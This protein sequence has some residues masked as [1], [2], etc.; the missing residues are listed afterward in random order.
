MQKKLAKNIKATVILCVLNKTETIERCVDS[1]LA[2]GGGFV[3]EILIVD[4]G[5]K[6]GSWEKLQKYKNNS[7]IRLLE[8][9]GG[10][11]KQLNYAIGLA[12]Y[13]YIALTDA[14]CVVDK[15][16]LKE[17]VKGFEESGVVATAGYCG[18]PIDVSKL[19][20]AIGVELESRFKVFPEYLQR[21]PT[22]SLC[23][24]SKIAKKLLFDETIKVG[25]ETDFGYRL[26][27]L[28]KIKYMPNS[29]VWHYHRA[30][31]KS[32]F[33]Q[34]WNTARGA[35]WVY[36]KHPDKVTGDHITTPQMM[37]EPL[38]MGLIIVTPILSF[39][40]LSARWLFWGALVSF[41]FLAYLRIDGIKEKQGVEKQ[42][43]GIILVRNLAFVIG[44]LESVYWLVTQ[45][46]KQQKF[47]L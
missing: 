33:K 39:L 12:K 40:S 34:Q 44:T 22:M 35:F 23:V 28:G 36:I 32:Y 4:G 9:G 43:W 41:M 2:L 6:D 7:V 8:K 3:G 10:Y 26:N 46:E 5:S 29:I 31:W 30:S 37:L 42:L 38:L 20:R 45:K 17:L 47:K 24:E 21:A 19:Q 15:N 1:L 18:T 11:S 27:K 25:V 16:W 13:K 14:D